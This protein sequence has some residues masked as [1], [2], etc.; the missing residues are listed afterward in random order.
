GARLTVDAGGGDLA[1]Q[2]FGHQG[3]VDAQAEVAAERGHPVVPPAEDP[4]LVVQQ[5]VAV[6]QA[7]AEQVAQGG[8]LG[9]RSQDV[10]LVPYRRIVHVA[11]V[12][13]DVEVA[14]HHQLRV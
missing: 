11:F 6:V 7:H 13:R 8:A 5:A 9:G 10:V 14:Q 1:P 2:C 4:T 12:R 3:Q